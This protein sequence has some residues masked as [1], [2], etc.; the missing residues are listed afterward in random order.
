MESFR[1]EL[2]A[3]LADNAPASLHHTATS[4]FHGHWGGRTQDFASEDQRL[5]FERCLAR[6]WTAPTWPKAYGG[7]EMTVAEHRIWKEEL[8]ALGMPLPLV[9]FGLTMIGPILLSEGTEAQ[10]AE[11]VPKIVRGEIRWCQGYSE[12][13]AGS[14]LASLRTRGVIDGD[15]MVVSGQKIWTSHADDSDWIFCLVRTDPDVR[16][17][18]G[19]SFVLIDMNTPGITVRP[20]ELISGASPFCETFFEDVRVPLTHVVGELHRGWSVAKALLRH[21][22]GMVGESIAAG[23]ARPDALRGY[24]LRKHA[25][26][27]IGLGDDGRLDDA[28]I[29]DDLIRSEMEQEAMR[30]TLRRANDR[31]R[32]GARPGPESSIF[33][34]V[35]TEL[36]QRR[37]ELGTRIAGLDGV[38]WAEGFSDRDRCLA[39]HWLRSRGNTIEGGTSEIQRN[40][41]A[42]RVLGLPKG[43]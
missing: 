15:E 20:I 18:E 38:G 36:N 5:W 1:A 39:T 8:I 21:E 17:Q 25:L 13:D 29:R 27:S 12:P 31:L 9:G 10:K 34:V 7:A 6:G 40:I 30:Q 14:D 41:I 26:A 22:R 28:A 23:G 32:S 4:P 11:H 33:K 43:S 3:W 19:I 35:G 24:T 16:K 2:K 42:R 37:W